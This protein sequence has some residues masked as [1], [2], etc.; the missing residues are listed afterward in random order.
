MAIRHN[1]LPLAAM[2]KLLKMAGADRVGEDAKAALQ[3]VLEEHA[4]TLGKRAA[5]YAKH[6][7]RKTVRADDI[8]LADKHA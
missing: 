2:E 3:E 8:T 7:D 4:M 1:V 6:A 5:E